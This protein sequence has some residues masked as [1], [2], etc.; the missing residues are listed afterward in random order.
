MKLIAL[1]IKQYDKLFKEQIFNFSDEYKVN[2]DFETNELK[3]DEN[4]DYIE[5]FYGE[6]IYNITPIVGIN[7]SGKST[8]LELIRDL[9]K[10]SASHL[11]NNNSCFKVFKKD[12]EKFKVKQYNM[13]VRENENFEI[14][15]DDGLPQEI[16]VNTT[17]SYFNLHNQ[18]FRGVTGVAENSNILE[19]AINW[20]PLENYYKV[21]SEFY[22]K[23]IF[24]DFKFKIS[25]TRSYF[26]LIH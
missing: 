19:M 7:G 26:F 5:N 22:S 2:F 12:N 10:N 17:I 1:V 14:N 16:N 11:E 24:S 15:G 20:S 9:G 25:L 3:I 8:L 23:E 6:S 18:T 21:Y 4:P 13:T